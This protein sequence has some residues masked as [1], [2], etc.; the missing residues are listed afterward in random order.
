MTEDCRQET[1]DSLFFP[2]HIFEEMLAYCKE[3]FPNEAC[4]ILAGKGNEVSKIYKMTNVE[5]SPVSYLLDSR[6]QFHVMKEMRENDLSMVAIFHSHTSSEA[7]P[8]SKD[9]SLAFYEDAFYVIVSLANREPVVRGF[10]VREKE[11]HETEILVRK[12]D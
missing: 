2:G 10:T 8:S 12:A 7:Y 4:G 1:A 11:I 5:K 9:V 3:G 6:E